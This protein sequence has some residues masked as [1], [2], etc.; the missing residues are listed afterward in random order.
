MTSLTPA[1]VT[2][3]DLRMWGLLFVLAANMFIDAL[4]VSV[5]VVAAPSIGVALD[6][7]PTV[8]Q[9]TLSGFA[10]GFGGLLLFGARI[11]ALLG[12]R[13]VYLAA[14]LAFAAASLLAGLTSDPALLMATRFVKGFCAA[15]TA[16]TGLA[17]INTAYR[18]GPDRNRAVS[19]YTLF[20]AGGFTGGLLLSGLLTTISWRWA[21]AFSA[22]VVLLLFAFA[23]RL[24]PDDEPDG[25]AP[26]RYDVAG[27]ATFTGGLL[28]LVYAVSSVPAAGWMTA[29][30]IG[31]FLA[32]V[33]L[34][35]AFAVVERTTARPLLRAGL[36]AHRPLVRSALG[37]AALN[38]SY[39]GLLFLLTVQTQ[40][41]L[42][43][44]PLKTA[45]LLAPASL[46][47]AFTALF[48]GRMVSR[49]GAPR[50]IALGSLT[51]FLGYVLLLGH[52][53]PTAYA[54][55]ILPTL[56]LVAVGFVLAFAALNMQ[57]V[58]GVPAADRG[59]AGGM[60][61]TAVQAGAVLMPAL[62]AA[63]LQ[64][65]RPPHGA[66]VTQALAGHRPAL[67]LIAAVG[68]AG[69]IVGVTG[70]FARDRSPGRR[71]K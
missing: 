24:L 27:A 26:R 44:S 35:G 4:E 48:S 34:L 52:D 6:L 36:L 13:R 10:L 61:Q 9:W 40:T 45:L 33:L 11:V 64:A 68:A 42:G 62:V 22:P 65:N 15:L 20:G 70:L 3:W 41:V 55:D 23:R 46:P 39:L 49:F 31:S 38:G 51:P 53:R 25:A 12:R 43:W 1:A 5:L 57:A 67:L 69:L 56:L 66:S 58:A 60:Y 16:P 28:A 8:L 7:A 59:M 37:A 71:A 14:L 21:L 30:V 29:R 2:K 18:E 50:L 19:V 47:L 17:I 63:L 54:T 32:G